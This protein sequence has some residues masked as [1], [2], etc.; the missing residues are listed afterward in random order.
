METG[1]PIEQE[2]ALPPQSFDE[3]LAEQLHEDDLTA[4]GFDLV[5]KV[6]EDKRGR[7]DWI[8]VY[9]DGLKY[10]GIPF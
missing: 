9:K 7:N 2:S 6:E 10:L 3:N 4:L 5:Q 8:E 1:D